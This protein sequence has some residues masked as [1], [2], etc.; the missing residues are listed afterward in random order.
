MAAIRLFAMNELNITRKSVDLW[1][2]FV[3]VQKKYMETKQRF[4]RPIAA[5]VLR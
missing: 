4:A 3:S 1:R 5:T 2:E